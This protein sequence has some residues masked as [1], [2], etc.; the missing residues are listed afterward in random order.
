MDARALFVTIIS[1]LLILLIGTV[2]E[3]LRTL[4]RI[5]ARMALTSPTEDEKRA[6]QDD[7][8]ASSLV[9]T[10]IGQIAMHPEI[11][12]HKC[13]RERQG[14]KGAEYREQVKWQRSVERKRRN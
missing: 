6:I 7:S 11:W 3:I 10:G 4:R 5:E 14:L 13:I 1:F 2:K 12:I 9:P 8:L